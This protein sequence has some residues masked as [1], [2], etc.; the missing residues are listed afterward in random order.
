MEVRTYCPPTRRNLHSGERIAGWLHGRLSTAPSHVPRGW[1]LV[2]LTSVARLESGHTP[3]RRH[4]EYWHGEIPWISLH[5]SAELD[6]PEIQST[7]FQIGSL[8]LE[9][10]SARLLP[11]GTVVFSRTATVGKATVMGRPMATSQDFA[12]YVCGNRL[13]NHYLVHLFRFMAPEWKRLMAGST[14]NSIYMP[15]FQDL[16]ILLPALSEQVAI[17]EALSNTDALIESLKELLVKK[18]QL[19]QG[20]MQ[21]LLS[22]RRRLPG[23]SGEWEVKRLEDVADTDPE[24]LGSDTRP[25]YTFK[26]IALDD[27]DVGTLRHYSEQ[28]FRTAPAR[29]RRKLRKSDVLVSTV[30]PNLMSHHLFLDDGDDWVCSTGFSV[31][32]CREGASHPAYVYY[33]MFAGCVTSQIYT[34]LT[35]SNYP[36]INGGDVRALLIPF[37]EFGEQAAIATFLSDMD[38][39]IVALEA[40]LRK[41]SQLKQG[42]M[43]E[44]LTG[45]IRLV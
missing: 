6:V 13:H 20:A 21:D 11:K 32:R 42:M 9:N 16:Q 38:A 24:T 25:D 29:A 35:G 44:L 10:S 36:A 26:Y 4:P 41:A 33:H 45:R 31:V 30:R 12:N 18:R 19:K 2:Y 34:L 14:H 3:S 23:F 40:K 27:V 22:G 28:E 5:D 8:G 7:V 15:V 37:P 39:E 1:E 43:Q 17:A